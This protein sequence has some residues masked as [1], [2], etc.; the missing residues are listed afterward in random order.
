M[1]WRVV[2]GL[3]DEVITKK[4]G[5]HSRLDEKEVARTLLDTAEIEADSYFTPEQ[6]YAKSRFLFT[7][8]SASRTLSINHLLRFFVAVVIFN[9]FSLF[10]VFSLLSLDD[11]NGILVDS[12]VTS[13][14]NYFVLSNCL[15]ICLSASLSVWLPACLRVR[16]FKSWD[17]YCDKLFWRRRDRWCCTLSLWWTVRWRE[18]K[19]C[20]PSIRSGLSQRYVL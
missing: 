14:F 8:S 4:I 2:R 5:E 18:W 9:G 15:S 11:L 20:P 6:G 10:L 17:S 19:A 3:P 1:K 7:W 13:V 12:S 16:F